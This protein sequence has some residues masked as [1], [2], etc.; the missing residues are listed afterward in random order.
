MAITSSHISGLHKTLQNFSI[1]FCYGYWLVPPFNFCQALLNLLISLCGLLLKL[2]FV[3]FMM[4]VF[5][6]V[7]NSHENFHFVQQFG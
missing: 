3:K 2:Q 7:V 6:Y 4:W 5:S 1:F